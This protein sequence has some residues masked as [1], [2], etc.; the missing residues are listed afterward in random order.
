MLALIA[1]RIALPRRDLTSIRR[2]LVVVGL[3]R[4]VRAR[5]G[6]ER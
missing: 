5:F 6:F 3:V 1:R 4:A 2:A